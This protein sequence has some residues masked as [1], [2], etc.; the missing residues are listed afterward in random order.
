MYKIKFTKTCSLLFA[1]I[2]FTILILFNSSFLYS[3][4]SGCK[5]PMANNYDALATVNDG[6]CTY[7]PT[8][9]TPPV[10]VDSL[11]AVLIESSGLQMAGNYLW[12]FNDGGGAAAIYR[13]DTL[14]NN[15]LQTVNLGNATNVDWEDIAFDGTYFYV[16]DFGNNANG[17]RTD[18]KIYKFALSDIPGDYNENPIVTIP[19]GLIDI[20]NF[21]YN[22]QPQPPV[23]TSSNHT[24]FDCEA[25][26][27]DNGQIH[28]FTKN[29]I[30]LNTTHYVINSLTAGSYIAMAVDTLATNYLV[31]AADKAPG[32]NVVALLGYQTSGFGNHFMHLLSDYSGGKYFN[33]N[34]RRIDLPDATVMGQAEGITF[35]NSTYGYISN[36]KLF[37]IKQKLRSFN[38]AAFVPLYVLPVTL[39]SF[40]VNANNGAHKIAWSFAD[41]V[42]NLHVE[43]STNGSDFSVVKSYNN[44]I[45]NVFYYK[46]SNAINYYRISWQKNNG[47]I[48][49]SN[50]LS[51][52]NTE[53]STISK[54]LLN[55][56]GKL[57]FQITGGLAA[58]Y[59]F[60]IVTSDGKVLSQIKE[61]SYS[62]GLNTVAFYR[63]FLQDNFVYLSVYNH[64]H[65]TTVFLRVEK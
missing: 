52:K 15:I 59:S 30:D 45:G 17:G 43:Y 50:I 7:N 32:L 57:S 55:T 46:P 19:S 9:Y 1:N 56:D 26:I 51:I 58:A 37:S 34:K 61:R 14:S 40:T 22:G 21:T 53:Q 4:V 11:S 33:G 39:K 24:K 47:G 10:Q 27:I 65:V 64:G 41:E 49:Y 42:Q 8:S 6:S 63:S 23:A 60:K 44:S 18:L 5:D 12:S 20:I 25:M 13:I 54:F 38:T 62:P 36:E 29:W 28:L 2:L 48:E 16:G 35:R 31:T 3:Q